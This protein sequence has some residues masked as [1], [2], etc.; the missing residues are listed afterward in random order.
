MTQTTK[1]R[2]GE[3]TFFPARKSGRACGNHGYVTLKAKPP[4][5]VVRYMD[6]TILKDAEFFSE[7][8]AMEFWRSLPEFN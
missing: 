2:V 4:R 5:W 7:N 3:V 6:G 8:S 1:C